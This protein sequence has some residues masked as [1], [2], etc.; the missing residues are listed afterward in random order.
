MLL[1]ND[2]EIINYATAP[3]KKHVSTPTVTMQQ[4]NGVFYTV[5]FK[6]AS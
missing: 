2:L 6:R 3:Q 1:G 5:L 4:K